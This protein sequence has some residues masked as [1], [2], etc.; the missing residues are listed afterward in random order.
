MGPDLLPRIRPNL[1]QEA[2]AKMKR[3]FNL[4][5][6]QDVFQIGIGRLAHVV[7]RRQQSGHRTQE[8]Q[9]TCEKKKSDGCPRRMNTVV[10]ESSQKRRYCASHSEQVFTIL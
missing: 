10:G 9:S 8:F 1:L 4:I 3:I 6:P 5:A 2:A 7:V